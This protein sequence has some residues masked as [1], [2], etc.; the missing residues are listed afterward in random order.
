[1]TV[2]RSDGTIDGPDGRSI[3]YGDYGPVDAYAVVLWCHGAPG[4]R[5]EPTRHAEVAAAQGVRIVAVDRP[6]YGLSS[7]WAGRSIGGA[8]TDVATVADHLGIEQ[9]F[10]VGCSTGGAYA[11]AVAAAQP[12]RVVGVVACC[13]LTDMRWPEGRRMMTEAE[14]MGEAI[15]GI[16][17][18]PSR[19]A[20]MA[21]GVD[22]LGED[23]SKLPALMAQG[24]PPPPADLTLLSDPAGMAGLLEGMREA[25]HH[26]VQGFVDDRMADGAGW[27]SF[28]PGSVACPVRVLH[29]SADNVVPV[30]QASH[31]ADLVPGATLRV[32]DDLGHMSI[33]GEILTELAQFG[34]LG[35]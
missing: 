7:P 22:L 35:L 11:L 5:L 15:R 31:T 4:S 29:G 14:G 34:I 6:G 21:I 10:V 8:A 12:E 17:E 24:P 9:F 13:A 33:A 1:M 32:V 30:A 2:T 23:G 27:V 20:A 25:F 19:E 26:G 3:G 28:D 18:A 16:W